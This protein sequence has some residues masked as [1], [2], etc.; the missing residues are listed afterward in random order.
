MGTCGTGGATCAP[1]ATGQACSGGKCVC[2]ASSCPNGC[3]DT[4]GK[5]QT[6]SNPTCG[7]GGVACAVCGTGTTC[8]SGKCVC[9]AS[10]CGGGCCNGTSCLAYASESNTLC[11]SGGATCAP[12]ASGQTCSTANGTCGAT[13]TGPCTWSGGPS[14]TNGEITCYWFGQGTKAGRLHRQQDLLRLLRGRDRQ[15]QR[16]HLPDGDH[17][18]RAQHR[19]ALLRRLPG[20]HLRPGDLLRH[21]RRRHLD[22]QDDHRH[23]RRRVRRPARPRRTSISACRPR[24]RSG[25]ARGRPPATPR[26]A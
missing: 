7:T 14:S 6:S 20:R 16:R 25:S 13:S 11:G 4:S 17:R 8:S 22:G 1:C 19:D 21:V 3:C 5:C 12:C 2:N 24:S 10:S 26:A 15:Q 9:N 23:H 18:H